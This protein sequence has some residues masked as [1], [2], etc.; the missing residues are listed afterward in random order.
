MTT[1]SYDREGDVPYIALAPE[2]P[3]TEGTEVHPGIVPMFNGE[4]PVGIEILPARSWS[5]ALL[6]GQLNKAWA[7]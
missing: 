4:H 6:R 1:V 2:G 5:L 7:R 3:E